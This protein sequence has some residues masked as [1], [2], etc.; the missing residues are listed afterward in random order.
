M[1]SRAPAPPPAETGDGRRETGTREPRAADEPVTLTR[2]QPGGNAPLDPPPDPIVQARKRAGLW[3]DRGI[4][5]TWTLAACKRV[6]ARS[7]QDAGGTEPELWQDAWDR[8]AV[9]AALRD[10]QGP[11]RLTTPAGW[12][13]A[14]RELR[15]IRTE[16]AN[17]QR[18]AEE[19]EARQR[20]VNCEHGAPGGLGCAFCRTEARSA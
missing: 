10:T 16:E 15:R 17:R 14:G 11:A 2:D 6:V 3:P 7:M 4:D 8:L 13:L 18:Q 5:T 19:R 12:E 9:L 1:S 20:G